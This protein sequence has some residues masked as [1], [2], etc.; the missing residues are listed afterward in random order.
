MT[1]ALRLCTGAIPDSAWLKLASLLDKGAFG[2]RKHHRDFCPVPV[3]FNLHF[4]PGQPNALAHPAD[5]HAGA[6]R[7]DFHQL[8]RINTLPAVFD[9]DGNGA[10]ARG[11]TDRRRL[12]FRVAVNVG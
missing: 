11:N 9:L 8:F 12:A 7:V 10:A 2:D 4:T 1:V 6:V 5:S 3:G